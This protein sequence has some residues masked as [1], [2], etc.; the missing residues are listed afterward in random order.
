[1]LPFLDYDDPSWDPINLPK[2]D[3][4]LAM[5]DHHVAMVWYVCWLFKTVYIPIH[6]KFSGKPLD[7][8]WLETFWLVVRNIFYFLYIGNFI[9]PT[10]EV[11][12]FRGVAQPSTSFGTLILC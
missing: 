4:H 6:R 5:K 1:M 8:P 3:S 7:Q 10:E 12:F 2:T 11:I 9:I